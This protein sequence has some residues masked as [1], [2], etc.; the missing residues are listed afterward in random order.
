MEMSC[1]DW[2]IKTE[3]VYQVPIKVVKVV[4]GI[5]KETLLLILGIPKHGITKHYW[6]IQLLVDTLTITSFLLIYLHVEK[7]DVHK[8]QATTWAQFCI[9]NKQ[10]LAFTI[11]LSENLQFKIDETVLEMLVNVWFNAT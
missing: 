8:L 9:A 4:G 2:N 10:I 6:I 3:V 11:S 7:T 5:S 1:Y